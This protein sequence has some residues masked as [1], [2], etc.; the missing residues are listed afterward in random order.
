MQP[1]VRCL[2]KSHLRCNYSS[3]WEGHKTQSENSS[4]AKIP[5]EGKKKVQQ[6]EQQANYLSCH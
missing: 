6:Q 3:V 1:D 4:R 2:T 5:S